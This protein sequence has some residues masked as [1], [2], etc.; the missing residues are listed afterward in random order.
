MNNKIFI[1][2]IIVLFIVGTACVSA[3]SIDDIKDL[4]TNEAED[5]D[6]I[7]V[8]DSLGD[9]IGSDESD[10]LSDSTN[11]VTDWTELGS[12]VSGTSGEDTVYIGA[13]LTPSSQIV[14]NHDVTIIGSADTYIGGSSSSNPVSYSYIPIYSDASGLSITLKNIR[15]QNCGGNILVQFGGNGNYNIENCTF[16]NCTATGSHQSIVYLNYGYANITDC[17]FEKCTTSYGTVSNYNSASVN[18]VHMVVRETTFNDNHASIEPGAIN[19]CG[20][21]IVY[22]SIFEGN[23]ATWWAG[24][25][26]THTNANSTIVRS[27]FR[28]NIAGWNGG[29]LY[30]YS[31]LTVINSTFTGNEAHGSNGGAIAASN[32]GSKPYVTIENCDF[33]ENTATGSG[34][35][36][37]FGGNSLIIDNSRF[38]YNV[39]SSGN[40]GAIS[41]GGVST[42]TNS[43]FKYNSVT[44][45]KNNGRGGAVYGSGTGHLTVDNCLFVNNTAKDDDS[46]NALAY[47]YTGKSS[48]AAYFTYI[49]NEIYGPNNG[50]GSVYAANNYLNIEQYNNTISDYSSYVEPENETTG[51]IVTIPE[52]TTIGTQV[53]NA[54]LSGALGGTPLVD[55]DVI[56]V[57][58]G[59]S[60]YC[61]N[62]SD[63]ALLWNV[64]STYVGLDEYNNFHDLALH[65]GVLVAPCDGDK[66]YLFNAT[67]GS[68]IELNPSIIQGS[69]LY[70]PLIVGDTIYISSE[71][72]YGANNESWIAVIEYNNGVY[73]YVGS[74][75]DISGVSYGTHA[76]ISA[77]ILWNNYLWVNTINGLVRY[78][79]NTNTYSISVA[80]TVGKPVVGG[81]YIYVLTADNHICGVNANGNVVKNITVQGNVGS[82]LAIN[83]DNTVLYTVNANGNIYHVDISSS[84]AKKI[85]R[86]SV[87]PVSS[88]L[89]VGSD[90][91]LYIGDDAGIFWVIDMSEDGP[92]LFGRIVWACNVS[93]SIFGVPIIY[94]GIV[95]IGTNDTFYVLS[96]PSR[97]LYSSEINNILSINQ[98]LPFYN[99][100]LL[101]IG[102]DNVL[103]DL[104]EKP[105]P[106]GDLSSSS[107][108]Q[109]SNVIY[110]LD[111]HYYVRYSTPMIGGSI[112]YDEDEVDIINWDLCE[113]ITIKPKEGSNATIE[114]VTPRSIYFI[115]AINVTLEN[116]KFTGRTTLVICNGVQNL[117]VKGCTFENIIPGGT[118]N[119]PIV[120][121]YNEGSELITKNI[122]FEDCKFV[123][124]TS[125]YI[126]HL[127]DEEYMGNVDTIS[128][129]NCLFEDTISTFP[130]SSTI[131]FTSGATN[132][133]LENNTFC[134]SVP[135]IFEKTQNGENQCTLDAANFNVLTDSLTIGEIGTIVG[136][137]VDDKGNHIK[138]DSLKFFVNGEAQ[139]PSFDKGTGL[140]SISYTPVNTREVMVN[141]ECSN[142]ETLDF[143]T[144][145]IPVKCDS[146][147]T[148]NVSEDS[149]Y[150]SDVV[151]N[152]SLNST[153]SDNIVFNVTDS[154]GVVVKTI[155]SNIIGG[156][157]TESFNDLPA[158]TYT[159]TAY[160]AG[161]DDFASAIISK[162][163]TIAQADFSV[164]L[165]LLSE[166]VYVGDSIGVQAVLPAGASGSVTFRLEGSQQTITVSAETAKAIFAGLT[167]GEYT[168]YAVY[169]GDVNYKASEEVNIT[170]DVVKND[171]EF[172]VDADDVYVGGDAVI[173][174]YQLP[175]DATGNITYYVND[176]NIYI[177]AVGEE[178]IIS[179]LPIGE[180]SVR[181]VYS[182]DDKYNGNE[183]NSDFEVYISFELDEDEFGYGEDA[184]I[185]ITFDDELNGKLGIIVDGNTSGAISADVINGSAVFT[186]SN[187]TVGEHTLDLIYQG[188]KS[189][190]TSVVIT[191]G[192]N[193]SSLDDLT[194]GDNTISLNLPS[195][196]TGNLTIK[197][198]DNDAVVVPVFNGT[199]S[200]DLNNLSAGEHEISVAY[201]GN[202]PEFSTYKYVDVAKAAPSVSVNAPSSITAGSA[203]TL[204][205]NLPSDA[206]GVVLVDV[207]GKGYYAELS[208]GV[209]NV[210][211]AGLTAGDKI[212]NYKYL[213]DSKYAPINGSTTLKVT[214]PSAPAKKA[215]KVTLTLKK[216]TVKR[217]AK[218]L[219]IKA[220][221]KINGKSKKGLK[222]TF[223][224]KG[225]KYT[226]KTNAKGIAKIT[227]KKSVLKKLKK[228]K[229]VTYTAAYDKV[230]K[231]VTVKVKK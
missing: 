173:S 120:E 7:S 16:E 78:N 184:L 28:N 43:E 10:L 81:D 129:V 97:I 63:G 36:I 146:G 230:T 84:S 164:A 216:V 5:I 204:P 93:S 171:V 144:V 212:L 187:L 42:I 23:S 149:V 183:A 138:S 32:Y 39:A 165:S 55:G 70:A 193:I 122:I 38:N 30:S 67:T 96:N 19:N 79:L 221:L 37:S 74:I 225:K 62:I 111:G 14:I 195:D 159:V 207:D 188:D 136:E 41:A 209:A 228:G 208:N 101:G 182:G 31:H 170:F 102:F 54:S 224:F 229:K 82:T 155:S 26:H 223:K 128:F 137:L 21:L 126:I 226:A 211:V 27:V 131:V 25:I 8:E 58:N 113:N 220:T 68:E 214:A 109:G 48:T 52:G 190:G 9:N 177:R 130:K 172:Y 121:I 194:T 217:S 175:G 64:S 152:A 85:N 99:L 139:T 22:D 95:Y 29:A 192:P 49:N 89:V 4:S 150:G 119:A 132:V 151:V 210:A 118:T 196:A 114:F 57:P 104:N 80:N 178:L 12:K 83:S 13:N 174:V 167:K 115:A 112:E 108:N 148:L 158:G 143:T 227:V 157:A 100:E 197:V 60:I 169:S 154:S 125:G 75:L 73:S 160:Y 17:T 206:T 191:V 181:A 222:V 215:D 92:K 116:I 2:L 156:F 124:C 87:N 77:P 33:D 140:Y 123:N 110:Y 3:E 127:G 35:A 161:D 205:I 6:S 213:G 34:G 72:G 56:Y 86:V 147:L 218:K 46:G 117:T 69:S 1:S 185:N 51:D 15:F 166:N 94:N 45:N 53:W 11:P 66:L 202:Y 201:E 24:A 198:D 231:K 88:A 186:L 18:N 76:L 44:G 163:F 47:S 179:D 134:N 200:Y 91:Y 98:N 199:A 162:P 61:L 153:I 20:N 189:F 71:Y 65:N 142:V 105:I 145:H 103:T 141:V 40:G 106:A 90:G 168:V 133:H 107:F 50:V 59:H 203:I 176:E 135:I 219:V 180:Y